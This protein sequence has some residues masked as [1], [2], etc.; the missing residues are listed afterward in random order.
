MDNEFRFY[1]SENDGYR[2]GFGDYTDPPP[3]QNDSNPF[4]Q[5]PRQQPKKGGAGRIVAL[6]L[7]CALVS[8]AAGVG[9]A[10]WYVWRSKKKG[11]KCIG[12]PD[13]Q[14]CSGNCGNCSGCSCKN[15]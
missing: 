15:R 9:G 8:G 14:H 11:A 4:E 1:S 3:G 5:P 2:G 10:A 13:S 7:A 6:V 12:C